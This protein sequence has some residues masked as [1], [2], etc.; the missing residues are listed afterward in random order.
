[1]SYKKEFTWSCIFDGEDVSAEKNFS[2]KE[3]AFNDMRRR[4]N[5]V[6][7]GYI[8]YQTLEGRIYPAKIEAGQDKLVL[9]MG[10]KLYT[11]KIEEVYTRI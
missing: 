2:T 7:L 5:Y 3:E 9:Y 10:G 4:F 8:N 6:L 11:F 1:M